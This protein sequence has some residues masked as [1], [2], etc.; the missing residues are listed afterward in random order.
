MIPFR[1][2]SMTRQSGSCKS[3]FVSNVSFQ[4]EVV[5]NPAFATTISICRHASK[6]VWKSVD[7]DDQDCTSVRIYTHRLKLVTLFWKFYVP[8]VFSNC[9]LSSSLTSP[10]TTY[11]PCRWNNSTVARPI[12]LAPPILNTELG[13]IYL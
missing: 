10:N 2:V 8:R 6:V 7:N 3:P 4:K 9:I 5:C 1:F 11:A 12:P 13:T